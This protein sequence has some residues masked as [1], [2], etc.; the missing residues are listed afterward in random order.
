[1][2]GVVSLETKPQEAYSA[3]WALWALAGGVP[4]V[5]VDPLIAHGATGA[6]LAAAGVMLVAM[7]LFVQAALIHR[8]G[9]KRLTAPRHVGH[10]CHRLLLW[11]AHACTTVAT[12]LFTAVVLLGVCSVGT[13]TYSLSLATLT[14]VRV[15]YFAVAVLAAALFS[16]ARAVKAEC[17]RTTHQ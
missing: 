10:R 13:E 6:V 11:P 17:Y 4:L 5:L 2:S 12:V 9:W 16:V 1:M 14:P 8:A 15:L 3:M 7:L